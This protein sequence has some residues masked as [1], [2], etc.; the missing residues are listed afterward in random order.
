[1]L[2]NVTGS[3]GAKSWSDDPDGEPGAESWI[4]AKSGQWNPGD[5]SIGPDESV[6]DESNTEFGYEN[7][8]GDVGK[9]S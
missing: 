4:D 3:D 7:T 6:P 5:S 9:E 1:L 8:A 2:K